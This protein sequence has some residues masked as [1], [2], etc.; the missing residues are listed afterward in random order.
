MKT[1]KNQRVAELWSKSEEARSH[2]RQLWTD[3]SN[4]FSY[5]LRIGATTNEGVKIVFDFTMPAGHFQSM[6]TSQHVGLSKRYADTVMSPSVAKGV[7]T[8]S[9][10][11]TRPELSRF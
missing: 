10:P 11:E 2:N 4:L 6:T 3:G 9:K 7:E 1:T 5:N 8:F